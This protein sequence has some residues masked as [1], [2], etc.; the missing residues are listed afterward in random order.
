MA[1]PLIQDLIGRLGTGDLPVLA[2]SAAE[3]AKQAPRGERVAPAD[4]AD[5]VL[6]DP[7]FTLN[8]LRAVSTRK[9]SRL[10]SE[11]TTIEHAVM[12]FGAKPFFERFAKPKVLEEQFKANPAALLP[13]RR[14]LSRAHHAACQA[15]DWA[16]CRQDIESEEVYIAAAINDLAEQYLCLT[17]PVMADKLTEAMRRD[18]IGTAPAQQAL[19]GLDLRALSEALAQAFNLPDILRHLIDPAHGDKPRT[20]NVQLAASVARHAEFGWYGKALEED[21][22]AAATLLHLSL[23]ETVG[24]IHRT[25]VLA[26]RA[27]RWYLAPPAARWLPLLPPEAPPLASSQAV[28]AWAMRALREEAGLTRAVF[29]S[30]TADG[31]ALHGKLAFG[32]EAGSAFG[33]FAIDLRHSH[34]FTHLMNKPQ[35]VWFNAQMHANLRPLVTPELVAIIGEGEFFAGSIFFNGKPLGLLYAD[36]RGHGQLDERAYQRFKDISGKIS[37]ALLKLRR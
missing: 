5:I 18:P 26:A 10:S 16:I 4:I 6:R 17:A 23:D 7:F 30:C 3:I 36:R 14:T 29:A 20:Q 11:I 33:G 15:R 24:H 34:L 1:S 27:W 13:L 21:M 32:A 31:Q 22:A 28:L 35:N 25:A 2:A 8:V 19:L 9:R 37:Q 12:M